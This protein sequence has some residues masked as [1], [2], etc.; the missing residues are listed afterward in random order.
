[1]TTQAAIWLICRGTKSRFWIRHVGH[2]IV[3]VVGWVRC[4]RRLKLLL[5]HLLLFGAFDKSSLDAQTTIGKVLAAV[6]ANLFVPVATAALTIEAC[7]NSGALLLSVYS[8][9]TIL[10][11]NLSRKREIL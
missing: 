8:N 4:C 10:V 11:V 6:V 7:Q 9:A 5:F 3:V 2:A 1:V